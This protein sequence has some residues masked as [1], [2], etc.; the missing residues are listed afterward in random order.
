MP[1]MKEKMKK[2][3]EADLE[4]MQEQINEADLSGPVAMEAAKSAEEG[5]EEASPVEVEAPA[6]E[7]LRSS[8]RSWPSGM[9][10]T[11]AYRRTLKISGGAPGR[12]RKNWPL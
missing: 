12:K 4:D 5:V 8:Q 11:C 6:M 7:A 2:K 1:F 3:D 10:A 9:I